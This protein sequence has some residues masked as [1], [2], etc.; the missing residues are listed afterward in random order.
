MDLV[1][2]WRGGISAGK[3]EE[4]EVSAPQRPYRAYSLAFA[5]GGIATKA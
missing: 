2:R 3:I 1:G 5:G 4:P